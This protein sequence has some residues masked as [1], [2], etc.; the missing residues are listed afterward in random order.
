M[1][2][3]RGEMGYIYL[4]RTR[5]ARRLAATQAQIENL[6]TIITKMTTQGLSSYEFDSGEG[7]HRSTRRSLKEVQ[8]M[9]DRLYATESH[10]INELY[11]IGVLSV[12]VRR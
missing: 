12:R 9:I 10:L 5:I 8:D 3:N 6:E 4:R 7:R 11:G 1:G 2:H